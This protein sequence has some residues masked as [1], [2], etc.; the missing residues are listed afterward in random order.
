METAGA[1]K[2]CPAN[3]ATNIHNAKAVIIDIISSSKID[4]LNFTKNFFIIMPIIIIIGI[5]NN[6]HPRIPCKKKISQKS[7]F[8]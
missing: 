3:S 4:F 2:V 7:I 5:K 8:P 6:I 1:T